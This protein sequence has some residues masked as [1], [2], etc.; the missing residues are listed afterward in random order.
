MPSRELPERVPFVIVGAGFAGASTAWALGRRGL[1]PGVLIEQEDTYGFHASGRNAAILRLVEADPVIRVLA[2]HSARHLRAL[3]E[4]GVAL[5]GIRGGFTLGDAGSLPDLEAEFEA[6][7]RDPELKTELLSAAA[8]RSRA[9]LL[10]AVNFHAAIFSPA[11][12]VVD[13]HAL[14]TLYLRQ[15]REAGFGLHTRCR[16]EDLVVEAGRVTGVE[17]TRGRIRADI[18]VNASGAWAARLGPALLPLRPVRRHIFVSGPPAGGHRHSPF[19]WME[20]AAFYFRPEGD[21]LLLSPCDE[22]PMAA[23][24][25]PTDPA[26]AELLAEK[27]AAHAPA[28]TDLPIR[29]SWACLRTFAPDRRPFIGPDPALPGLFHVCGLGGFGMGTSAAVGELAAALLAGDR[30]TWIDAAVTS[31]TRDLPM[32]T[33]RVGDAG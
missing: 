19:A 1:G 11:E 3:E 17:T 7:R 18:V 8:A 31:P 27:L 12:A 14:L 15:A 22:T 30:P 32:Q 24:D 26:A 5:L 21:G 20:D 9:P 16:V 23:G 33:S 4:T 28:F 6:T 10:G 25:P 29:R 13:I 2:A